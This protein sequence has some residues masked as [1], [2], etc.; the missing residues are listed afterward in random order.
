MASLTIPRMLG[1]LPA[2][3]IPHRPRIGNEIWFKHKEREAAQAGPAAF[4]ATK[5]DRSI[6]YNALLLMAAFG[7]FVIIIVLKAMTATAAEFDGVLL[8]YTFFVTLFQLSRVASSLMYNSSYNRVIRMGARGTYQPK[9]SFVIPCMNEQDEIQNTIRTCYAAHY[10]RH[11]IEV[12]VINDASTDATQLKIF[13][14]KDLF[15]DLIIVDWSKNRGKRHGMAEGFWRSSGEIIIQLDS[16]SRIEPRDIP[17][18]VEPFRNPSVGAVSYHTDPANADKNVLT[19]MQA[20]YYYLSFRILKAAES[21]FRMVFCCSGCASAYRRSIVIP[22]LDTWLDETFLGLPVT[23]GDD[24]SLTNRVLALGYETLYSDK[25]RAYTICPDNI[26]QFIKQQIRW[27]KGWL[28]NSLFA[29]RF[30]IKRDPFVA[31]TY[32][33]PLM[34]VTIL[35]PFMAARA[36]IYTPIVYGPASTLF[37]ILGVYAIAGLFMVT[38]RYYARDNK[39]YPYIFLWATLN[40]FVL[41]YMLLIAIATIQDRKWGT[42]GLPHQAPSPQALPA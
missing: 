34:M 36:F 33:F 27:K 7:L 39:Y 31:A 19:R 5:C 22:I 40:M 14:M 4:S 41:S 11:L 17:Q 23:W 8:S 35:T 25:V 18:L 12:I 37:Y 32:F 29:A 13:E 38:Y 30:V 20:A 10:P 16:D 24:R 28:V 26:R 2:R 42:R 21:T 9:V 1:A 15:P 6:V 3:E